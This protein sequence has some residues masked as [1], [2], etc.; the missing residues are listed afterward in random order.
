MRHKTCDLCGKIDHEP[1]LLKVYD[2]GWRWHSFSREHPVWVHEGCYMK[3][4]QLE[5]C[6]CGKGY[7]EK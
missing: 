4:M 3:K 7:I 1:N 2:D 6:P 5:K